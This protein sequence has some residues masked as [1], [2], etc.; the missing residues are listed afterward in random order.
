MSTCRGV[1]GAATGYVIKCIDL[2]YYTPVD[3][4]GACDA[5]L[6]SVVGAFAGLTET[7]TLCTGGSCLAGTGTLE[8]QTTFLYDAHGRTCSVQSVNSGSTDNLILG[9]TYSYDQFDNLLA[10]TS[11]S[12]LDATTASNFQ[13]SYGYDGLMRLISSTRSDADGNF[14]ESNTYTYDA[15]S[16][17]TQKVQVLAV[18]DTPEPSPTETPTQAAATP[19][20]APTSCLGDCNGDGQ[21]TI[22]ELVTL[23]NIALEQQSLD[24]CS[25]GD[26]NGDGMITID[27]LM[28]A[29][30]NALEGC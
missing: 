9:T 17:I 24:R 13:I 22:S 4:G 14:L 5:S 11:A 12:D 29:V 20:A 30:N 10:E 2:D 16:N 21:V 19:T 26:G 7:E 25:L 27:E 15:A 18:T 6:S 23:V 1:V 8:Y 28:T 3:V